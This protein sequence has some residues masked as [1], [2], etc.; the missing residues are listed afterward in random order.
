MK[1]NV[2]V[3][4][5]AFL[6]YTFSVNAQNFCSKKEL[7]KASCSKKS[8]EKNDINLKTNV[9]SM[10]IDKSEEIFEENIEIEK[11]EHITT[12]KFRVWGN[13]GMCKKTIEGA[14]TDVKGVSKAEWN[15]DTNEMTVS[16]VSHVISLDDIKQKIADVGYDTDTHR[17][18]IEVYNAL[19]GCC[20]YDRP[21]AL[22]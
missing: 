1:K 14:L 11:I 4:A 10:M 13:C 15:V 5:I 9:K 17:A 19:H 8:K 2:L 22:D 16:F 7:Q 21:K 3:I 18:T 12:E 20:Q 6:G